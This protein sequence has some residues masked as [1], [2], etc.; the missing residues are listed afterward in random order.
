M[1]IQGRPRRKGP[2]WRNTK[3]YQQLLQLLDSLAARVRRERKAAQL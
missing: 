3:L 2:R 1:A